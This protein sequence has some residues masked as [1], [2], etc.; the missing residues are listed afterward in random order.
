MIS[1]EVLDWTRR[2]QVAST[3]RTG[4]RFEG[5]HMTIFL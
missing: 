4:D 5:K 1:V 2:E 3:E